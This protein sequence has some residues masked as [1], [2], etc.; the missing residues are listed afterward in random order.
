MEATVGGRLGI[1]TFGIGEDTGEP[2]TVNYETPFAFTGQI[3]K[4]VIEMR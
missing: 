3:K 1:D 2:V 4:V